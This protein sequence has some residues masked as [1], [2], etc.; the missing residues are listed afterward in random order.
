MTILGAH[1]DGVVRGLIDQGRLAVAFQPIVALPSLKVHAY[2][3]LGRVLGVDGVLTGPTELL[4]IAHHEGTNAL[5]DR[6]FQELTI[7]AARLHDPA[8]DLRYFVNIDTCSIGSPSFDS[9]FLA[10]AITRAGLSPDH[11]SIELTERGPELSGPVVERAA[12]RYREQGFEIV[13]DDLGAGYASLGALVRLRPHCIKLDMELVRR[14]DADPMRRHLI[15]SLSQFG[16]T[17]GI[18]VIAEGIETAPELEALMSAGIELG[19]GYLLGRPAPTPLE[20]G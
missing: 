6:A 20:P 11:F 7:A 9:E 12:A 10:R 3:V 17:C 2:E 14:L 13:L 5:L 15:A 8:R 1:E 16:R 4:E 19:Q 18:A